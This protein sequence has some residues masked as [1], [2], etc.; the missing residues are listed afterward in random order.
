M[1][2][3]RVP[4]G[5]ASSEVCAPALLLT[6]YTV[7][8]VIAQMLTAF[9]TVAAAGFGLVVFATSVGIIG[10]SPVWLAVVV[11]IAGLAGFRVIADVRRRA[12]RRRT[13]LRRVVNDF[14]Q[15]LAVALTTNRSVED[16]VTFAAEAG[17]GESFELLR[18]TIATARP[19]GIS[20]LGCAERHGRPLRSVRTS[21][22]DF[23]VAAPS[24]RRRVPSQPPFEPKRK[25]LRD[26]QLL[27]LG[28]R[29]DKANAN[30]S[31]P[32]MGMVMGMVLFLGYPI[33]TR[34]GEAFT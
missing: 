27:E 9:L 4:S 6:G 3:R 19:M 15:L 28:E 30:L 2:W 16:S 32:T 18:Q 25:A 29:A 1:R 12:S 5:A 23:I 21:W 11:L 10:F 14:V 13:D 24:C 7:Q 20:V 34:I 22:P 8:H 31:L 33:L 26:K 17:E